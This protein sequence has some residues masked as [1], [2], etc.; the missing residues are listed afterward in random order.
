M[1]CPVPFFPE[2]LKA[3]AAIKMGFS[4]TGLFSLYIE[5]TTLYTTIK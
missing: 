1:I 2:K 4:G 3:T 5:T